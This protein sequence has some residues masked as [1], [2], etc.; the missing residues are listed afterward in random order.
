MPRKR[1]SKEELVPLLRGTFNSFFTH[2]IILFPFITIAFIQILVLEILYFSPRFPL[3]AFFN[4]IIQTL[5]G[6]AF[7]HYPNNFIILPKLF[8]NAQLSLYL[9]VSS[10]LIAVAISI[11]SAINDNRK[12][13]FSK[14]C[15]DVLSQYV[16]VFIAALLT[17]GVFWGFFRAYN[18]L[19]VRVLQ[20]KSAEGIFPVIKTIVIEGAP[21]FNL[22]IGALVT[23]LFAFVLPLIVIDKRKIFSAVLL[24]FRYLWGS[25][26]LVAALV[27]APVLLYVPVLMLRGNAAGI[28]QATFPEAGALILAAGILVTMFIDAMIYTA[29]TMFYLLKKESA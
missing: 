1:S 29:I 8:R 6:E 22:I 9:F 2:P 12:I 25:F 26:W 13:K 28:A 5:W 16:H 14:A 7:I 17:L 10:F 20:I 27:V 19:V 15:R 18:L 24:N 11:I 21:Y 3:S 4:P 23:T